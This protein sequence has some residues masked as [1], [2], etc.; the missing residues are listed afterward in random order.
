M[1][2]LLFFAQFAQQLYIGLLGPPTKYTTLRLVE[3]GPSEGWS[4]ELVTGSVSGSLRGD[5]W[6]RVVFGWGYYSVAYGIRTQDPGGR[7]RCYTAPL[8]DPYVT[9]RVIG[10][11]D[12]WLYSPVDTTYLLVPVFP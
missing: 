12:I 4:D 6:T 10:Y 5:R 9:H 3:P 11:G 2:L 7:Y 1:F 8:P